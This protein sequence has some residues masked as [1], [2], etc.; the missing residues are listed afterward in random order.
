MAVETV[1]EI[2]RKTWILPAD[3]VTRGGHIIAMV[4]GIVNVMGCASES[5]L[6]PQS[7][8]LPMAASAVYELLQ[9]LKTIIDMREG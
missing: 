4:E 7:D 9:E 2:P 8:A 1:P 6:Q 5:E 3:A